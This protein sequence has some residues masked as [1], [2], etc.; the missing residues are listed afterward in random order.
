MVHIRDLIAFMTRARGGRAAGQAAAQ[1]AAGRR[2]RSQG[3]RSVDAAVRRQASCARCCSCR[4][5]C[6]RS[7]CWRKMQA[8]RI[9]LALVVD[10]YGGTDGLVSIEDIVEQIV[11]EI[12]DEHDED[13]RPDVVRQADGS[14]LADARAPARGRHRRGRRGLRRRRGRRGGRYARRL[15][16]HPHRPRAGA[17]R[18]GAGPRRVRDRGAR[19][20]SAPGQEAADLSG[21]TAATAA[22]AKPAP[23]GRRRARPRTATAR[24]RAG[25]PATPPI[26][27]TPDPT[28]S[29]TPPDRD[30]RTPSPIAIVLAGAGGA[31]LVAFLAGAVSALALAPFNAW[32]VLFLTFPV[33]VWLI[34]GAAAGRLGG[35]AGGSAAPAGGSASAISSPAST[36]SATRFLVDAKTFG[37]LLPF[38]VIGAAGRAG[39]LHRRSASALAR[40]LWTRGPMPHPRARGRAH[41]RRMAA[42]PS[43]H[44]LSLERLRLCADRAAAAGAGRRADR[45][46]GPDLPRGR[47]VREPGG[48]GRRARRH[49]AAVARR[50]ALGAVAA[51]RRW[52]PTARCGCARTPTAYRRRRAAAHHAA[53]SA[54]GR[55][56]QLRRQAAQVM[57]RY[58]AL[59]DR[60][61][62]PRSTGIRDV[63]HLIWPESAFPFFLTRDADALAQIAALLPPG[64]VLITGAVRAP[65]RRPGSQPSRAPTIR[66][67]SSIT[68]ARSCRSTTR[69]IWCRSANICRSRI[70]SNGSACGSSPR[71]GAASSRATGAAS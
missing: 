69:S 26:K 58:L 17:R 70:F 4:R 20:R 32:P 56:I 53:Q 71:C 31:S 50:S 52:R 68:T 33:L 15:Y 36:G 55:E 12:E 16:G 21:R 8:T 48:A 24:R 51:R 65:E 25:E 49:P 42:R 28:G 59:S 29:K 54:A 67:T 18:A 61:S 22:A 45:H 23:A 9:H 27:P 63:T 62:G 47:G 64:T 35:V 6:R 46:L 7:T 43:A 60:A 11:G 40:L 1:E 3:D 44:R 41:R 34:D 5:R 2:P 57:N 14:F 37:W 38:A 39:A 10:E 13:E 66:S 30:A 19:C